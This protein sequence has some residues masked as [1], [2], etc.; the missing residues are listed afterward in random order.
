MP[1]ASRHHLAGSDIDVIDAA[2]MLRNY[3]LRGCGEFEP[4]GVFTG[5]A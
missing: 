3:R 4:G 1:G 5:W 2:A